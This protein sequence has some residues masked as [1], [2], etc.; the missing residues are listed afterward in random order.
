MYKVF[1]DGKQIG[2]FDGNRMML[3]MPEVSSSKVDPSVLPMI[4]RGQVGLVLQDVAPYPNFCPSAHRIESYTCSFRKDDALILEGVVLKPPLQK[5]DIIM[6]NVLP[7]LGK[8]L[9]RLFEQ[10]EKDFENMATRFEQ[11]FGP[12]DAF[13]N[14]VVPARSAFKIEKGKGQTTIK[15]EVPGCSPDKVQINLADG[16]VTVK[17][18]VLNGERTYPFRVGPK[19]DSSDISAI[20]R[21]GLLTLVVK[22]DQQPAPPSGTVKVTL[23]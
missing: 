11:E 23:G 2:V 5:E 9:D 14:V 15:V 21:D 19:V 10:V 8:V 16:I 18:A 6:A 1:L 20:V 4:L 3:S 17:A 13:E 7:R 22:R 12:T